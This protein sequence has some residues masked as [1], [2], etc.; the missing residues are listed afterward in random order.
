MRRALP[1]Q[2]PD[3]EDSSLRWGMTILFKHLLKHCIVKTLTGKN[4]PKDQ[5]LA[6][7]QHYN[8]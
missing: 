7:F 2:I 6:T 8:I 1:P 5:N 4:P 3:E